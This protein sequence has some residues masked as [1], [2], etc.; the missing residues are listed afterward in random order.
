ME[1]N[2]FPDGKVARKGNGE[3]RRHSE[4][5]IRRC[6]MALA[7]E[8]HFDEA[9][10]VNGPNKTVLAIR[11]FDLD[12]AERRWSSGGERVTFEI[13]HP[14]W[15]KADVQVQTWRTTYHPHKFEFEGPL[16]DL[17]DRDRIVGTDLRVQGSYNTQTRKGHMTVM[18]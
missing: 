1:A 14:L 3:P 5:N 16:R 2:P 4:E 9:D 13:K 12:E 11:F 7:R 8:L 17:H 15:S 6:R 18:K 10:I